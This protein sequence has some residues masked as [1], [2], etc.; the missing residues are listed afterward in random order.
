METYF[1][2]YF[3]TELR[4]FFLKN[5]VLVNTLSDILRI[6]KGAVYRRLRQDVPFTFNEI[7]LISKHLRISLD[8]LIGLDS[9]EFVSF[10]S[11]LPD[12][13]SPQEADYSILEMYI[14]FL[15]SMS[16]SENSESVSAINLLPHDLFGDF[17][18][19][20]LFYLF[21]WNFLYNKDNMK[22]FNQISASPEMFRYLKEY[23]IGM[24]NFKKTSYIFDN[25]IFQLI[26]DEVYYFYNI[27][28]IE[29]EDVLKI[30]EDLF[31]ILD[32]IEKMAITG[33]FKETGNSVSLFI[34][35]IDI[36]TNYTYLE[37][38]NIYFSIVKMFLLS[39]VTSM[40]KN[41]FDKMK[42]W[43]HSLIK[44]STLITLTNEKQRVLYFEKQRKIVSEL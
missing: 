8:N 4:K 40:D 9:Q 5:S 43:L 42:K 30:K 6:E 1:Y 37:S 3:L 38:N 19:L 2:N 34:S 44:I 23:S 31:S 10:Q 15:L 13:I 33:Q 35:D 29:K 25:R 36:S 24:K 26:V 27:R 12:F 32:Y 18:Y 21:I 7:A 17:Q 22:P 20:F 14:K 39:S 41:I 16:E 11:Q 28:L